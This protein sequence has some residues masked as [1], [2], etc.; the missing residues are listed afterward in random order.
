MIAVCLHISIVVSCHE[1]TQRKGKGCHILKLYLVKLSQ[2][3]IKLFHCNG[4][5]FTQYL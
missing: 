2:V 3:V 1:D 4:L 5:I